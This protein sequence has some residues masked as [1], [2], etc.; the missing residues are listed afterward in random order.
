[1]GAPVLNMEQE[2]QIASVEDIA[3]QALKDD[4]WTDEQIEMCMRDPDAVAALLG[5]D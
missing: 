1:M 3:R 4:G 2:Q 5:L